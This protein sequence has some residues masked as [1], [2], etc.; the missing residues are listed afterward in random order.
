MKRI[1]AVLALLFFTTAAWGDIFDYPLKQETMESFRKTCAALAAY[2]V[3]KGSFEQEKVLNRLNRSLKSSGNFL[4]ASGQG[5]VWDTVK[6]FPSALALG[7]DYLVQSRPGG[8]R[9]VLSA[10]G[11]ETFIRM[12]EVISAVFSG[13]IS[14][15]MENFRVYYSGA[16]SAW[17]LGLL[18]L[19]K[20][21]NNFA[22]RI[23]MKGDSVIKSITVYEQSGDTIIYGLSNHSYS[24]DLSL[25]EKAFFSF[26]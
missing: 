15:L 23:V 3:V 19:D 16:P 20:A 6:P 4:I 2:P 13:N 8:E 18:P 7:K 17:E 1:A 9:T 24:S 25:N 26:P 21:I 5:M 10:A 11:N 22:L 12:A 14:G